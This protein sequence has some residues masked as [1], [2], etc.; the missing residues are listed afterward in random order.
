VRLDVPASTPNRGVAKR[1]SDRSSDPARVLDHHRPEHQC[2]R[3]GS[4]IRRRSVTGSRG[5]VEAVGA[6][7]E[8]MDIGVFPDAISTAAGIDDLGRVVGLDHNGTFRRPV[9]RSMD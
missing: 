3:L 9:W 2:Q 5:G 4:R 7:Y 6:G 8:A 1:R